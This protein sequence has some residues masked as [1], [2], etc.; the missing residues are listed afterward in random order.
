MQ[1]FMNL[2]E[3]LN[4]KTVSED[5]KVGVFELV[6]LYTGYGLTVGTALRRVLLS[7]LPGAAITQVKVRSVN[8]EFS[9]IPGVM[10]DVVEIMLNLKRVRFRLTGDEPQTLILKYK[11]EGEVTAAEIKVN[12]MV[13]L[14]TPEA[15]IATVTDKQTTLDM[16]I[17]IERGMGYVPAE[18]R[19]TEKLPIGVI[20]LDA[21]FSPVTKA[22]FSVEHMRV[23]E[24]TDYDLLRFVIETD[25]SLSPSFAFKQ[26]GII[27]QEYF[28]KIAAV[29]G[30]DF[31]GAGSSEPLSKPKRAKRASKTEDEK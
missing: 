11:G 24:R 16:E 30:N 28:V 26:A 17:T 2:S 31:K 3:T 20:A 22:N 23:G 13:E 27:L 10:E 9:T 29:E 4:I 5:A 21:I 12:A 7:S 14:I 8:H 1:Y 18:M 6:G 25:G 19:K 15:H